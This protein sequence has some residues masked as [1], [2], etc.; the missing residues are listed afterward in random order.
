MAVPEGHISQNLAVANDTPQALALRA[1][2]EASQG[3]LGIFLPLA[4]PRP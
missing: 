2:H 4:L 3:T 1:H